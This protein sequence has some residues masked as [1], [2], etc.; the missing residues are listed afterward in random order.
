ML[1]DKICDAYN[2]LPLYSLQSVEFG[3]RKI[4]FKFIQ[5]S[6]NLH[7]FVTITIFFG[8]NHV[9]TVFGTGTEHGKLSLETDAAGELGHSSASA[10][11]TDA[12]SSSQ[13]AC[14]DAAIL[15]RRLA[16]VALQ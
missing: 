3:S 16:A 8:N 10:T 11:I 7:H 1:F 9:Y 12:L 14:S 2:L 4:S 13:H 15:C 6:L 5:A